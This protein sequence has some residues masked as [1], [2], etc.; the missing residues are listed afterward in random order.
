MVAIAWLAAWPCWSASSALSAQPN[1]LWILTEDHGPMLGAY[2]DA[3]SN[4]PAID[5]LAS[6]GVTYTQAFANAPVCSPARSTLISGMYANSLGSHNMPSLPRRPSHIGFISDYLHRAGYY[7]AN[8]GK[9]DFNFLPGKEHWDET[10]SNI[11]VT[12]WNH[13]EYLRR[14]KGNQP[15]FT[16][17]NL[18]QSHESRI[19]PE[20]FIPLNTSGNYAAHNPAMAPVPPYHPNTTS[21]R[22]DLA[23]YYDNM[24]R[25]DQQVGQLLDKLEQD[26]LLQDTIVFM[27]SD[28]GTGLPRGKRWLYD[29]GLRVPLI[30]YIP[31]RFSHLAPA[32]VGERSD[33]LVSFVDFAPTV[34]NLA[35]VDIPEHM[36]GQPFLGK[37][38]HSPQ[39]YV[40]SYR[41]RMDGRPDFIRAVT[42][43]RYKYIRN[44]LPHRSYAQHVSFVYRQNTMQEW[45][46]F[47]DAGDLTPIQDAF[48]K[49]KPMEELY[50]LTSDPH[51]VNNLANDPEYAER[52]VTMRRELEQWMVNNGDL[53]LIPEAEIHR[54]A[55]GKAP[56]AISKQLGEGAFERMLWAA[57]QASQPSV[58]RDVLIQMIEHEDSIV[59]YWGI[60]GFYSYSTMDN[61]LNVGLTSLLQDQS[62]SVQIAA[63]ELLCM[64][65]QCEVAIPVLVD[66]LEHE[67][68]AV[69]L[70]A[71]NALDY[72]DDRAIP[73]RK[74][75][76]DARSS[77]DIEPYYRIVIRGQHRKS[78]ANMLD[79]SI[80]SPLVKN[81]LDKALLDLSSSMLESDKL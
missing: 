62:E 59:R 31:E 52:K 49:P 16:I 69:R 39:P 30:V 71:A 9:Y 66:V 67:D 2:G 11:F 72:L 38:S 46:Q 17:I 43:G 79:N 57:N 81:V 63:A 78:S 36:Q 34:L 76:I 19:F 5:Q 24:S 73:A 58:N 3:Y 7:T 45:Q 48:F 68:G 20:N 29:S 21:T 64:N 13:D 77:N 40:F 12:G 74:A 33:E 37:A 10:D 8:I 55:A 65:D 61:E 15:F 26:G 60:L 75:M 6:K 4:T 47:H 80:Y 54:L 56:I 41:D 50:D 1:I 18:F 28:H 44:Y 51:E 70:Q 27:F 35:G 22:R 32:A 25:V 14:K 23:H 42:D 53:G